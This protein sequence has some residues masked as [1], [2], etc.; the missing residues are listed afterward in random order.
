MLDLKWQVGIRSADRI[1][2]LE[3]FASRPQKV[4]CVRTTLINTLFSVTVST[5]IDDIGPNLE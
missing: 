3:L 5:K 4:L 1:T 2:A